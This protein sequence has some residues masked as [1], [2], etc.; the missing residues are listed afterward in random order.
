[1]IRN[2]KS[3][4]RY[5]SSVPSGSKSFDPLAKPVPLLGM[6]VYRHAL[7]WS[8]KDSFRSG[9]HPVTYKVCRRCWEKSRQV[10][11]NVSLHG[12]FLI[13]FHYLQVFKS[14][15]T[16]SWRSRAIA[17][18][19]QQT[20]LPPQLQSCGAST[21]SFLWTRSSLS[22]IRSLPSSKASQLSGDIYTQRDFSPKYCSSSLIVL[23]FFSTSLAAWEPSFLVHQHY[24]EAEIVS[25]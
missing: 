16:N 8:Q 13:M 24:R 21:S 12:P 25:H 18:K 10:L 22:L 6:R 17:P 19:Q 3:M 14:N 4:E 2:D 23:I 7:A 5:S 1:M 20:C 11:R 9:Q 15:V